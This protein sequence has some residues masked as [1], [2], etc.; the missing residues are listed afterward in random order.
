M[1]EP[2]QIFSCWVFGAKTLPL[3]K[4]ILK[5]WLSD[6]MSQGAGLAHWKGRL[7]LGPCSGVLRTSNPWG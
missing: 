5:D 2:G 3:P 4:T 7:F 1:Q 6:H